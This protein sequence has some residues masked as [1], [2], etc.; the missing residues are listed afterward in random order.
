M[1]DSKV[2]PTDARSDTE[3]PLDD[4]RS[5]MLEAFA[6][7]AILSSVIGEGRLFES[8][9]GRRTP[10]LETPL[11]RL[12]EMLPVLD[13]VLASQP[14]WDPESVPTPI[15]QHAKQHRL[16]GFRAF[17][18]ALRIPE[19]QFDGDSIVP[20]SL[21]SWLCSRVPRTSRSTTGRHGPSSTTCTAATGTRGPSTACVPLRVPAR[22]PPC[23][24]SS[25]APKRVSIAAT[26]SS[27][28]RR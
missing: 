23:S 3:A 25:P 9:E 4:R 22:P 5:V 6:M 8:T 21:T 28:R 10:L 19:D 7:V 24:R 27:A 12:R 14:A 16:I 13:S 2:V 26:T 11:P 20:A 1:A 17:T 15:E 18:S